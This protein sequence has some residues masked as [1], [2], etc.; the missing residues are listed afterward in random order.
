MRR[1]SWNRRRFGPGSAFL[2]FVN[3][4]LDFHSKSHGVAK[5]VKAMT[6]LV[7]TESL[8]ILRKHARRQLYESRSSRVNRAASLKGVGRAGDSNEA[9]IA[10]S[11]LWLGCRGACAISNFS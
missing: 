10:H 8:H 7:Q 5:A 2:R 11:F 3:D 6:V 4:N 1:A 9:G